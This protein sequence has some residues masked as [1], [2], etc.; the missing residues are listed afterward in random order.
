MALAIIRVHNLPPY[1]DLTTLTFDLRGH[2]DCGWC[3]SSSSI[4]TP[5]L[6]FVGLA[7]RKIWRTMCVSINGLVTLTFNLLSLKLV[8][9]LH[10]RCGIF[11]PNLSTLD[12][13]VLEL[14]AMY[15]IDGRTKATLIA[16]SLWVGHNKTIFVQLHVCKICHVSASSQKSV[17]WFRF[18][19]SNFLSK[20]EM[21][22]VVHVNQGHF[23]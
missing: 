16:P 20:K 2:G 22:A 6:K 4:C 1:L 17:V 8:R 21:L 5:S 19:I 11:L 15:A 23:R 13:W 18:S 14:F 9:E 12:R 10:L 7:V 3:G